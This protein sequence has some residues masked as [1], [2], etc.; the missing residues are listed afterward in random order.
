[1]KSENNNE[2]PFEAQRGMTSRHLEENL[3]LCFQWQEWHGEEFDSDTRNSP[4]LSLTQ[5]LFGLGF[6]I[7]CIK[8]WVDVGEIL[9]HTNP[10]RL[11]PSTTHTHK[12]ITN[13]Q[14]TSN[15]NPYPRIH[16]NCRELNPSP[17][18]NKHKHVTHDHNMSLIKTVAESAREMRERI[19]RR[20]K[21][22]LSNEL[23]L[24]M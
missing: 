5:L 12:S 3:T 1:M 17:V 21:I 13:P 22:E 10:L 2:R 11:A 16:H 18:K 7:Y 23:V 4:T 19:K 8:A 24:G 15:P 9:H 20:R 14:S 6:L